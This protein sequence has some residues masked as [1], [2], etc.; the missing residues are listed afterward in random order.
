MATQRRGIGVAIGVNALDPTH[1]GSWSGTLKN[2]EADAAAIAGIGQASGFE[3]TT[4]LTAAATRAALMSVLDRSAQ[5]LGPGDMLLL[6]YSGHGGQVPD[7]D[8]DEDDGKDE[9]WCLHD[10]VVIDDELRL[11]FARLAAGVRVL[12]LSDSCHSGTVI[13]KPG[14]RRPPVTPPPGAIV[15][16]M[17]GDVAL[18]TYAQHREQ[19]GAIQRAIPPDI[20][21]Q[22]QAT[23]RLLSACQDDELAYDGQGHGVFIAA[24]LDVWNDG[25]FTGTYDEFHR[26]IVGRMTMP[27]TP[28]HLV[29]GAPSPAFDAERPFTL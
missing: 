20:T 23:V 2:C 12:V 3:M 22:I 6:A 19:Y 29:I 4:L 8:G 17:P 13:R 10:G 26:A 14:D 9:T 11:R 24:L 5:A 18:R 21:G 28:N 16:A 27:Q 25:R 1:Y 7:L 15:R